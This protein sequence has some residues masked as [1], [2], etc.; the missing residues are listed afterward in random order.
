[1]DNSS[2][3]D[4]NIMRIERA[5][6]FIGNIEVMNDAQLSMINTTRR[7]LKDMLF[8]LEVTSEFITIEHN[9]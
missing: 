3:K 7:M 5:L 1:M 8:E 6:A 2:T 4:F 9:G